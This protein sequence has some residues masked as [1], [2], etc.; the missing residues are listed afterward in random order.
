MKT[1]VVSYSYVDGM[2]FLY[3]SDGNNVMQIDA[4]KLTAKINGT[5]VEVTDGINTHIFTEEFLEEILQ[6]SQ[7][8]LINDLIG[9]RTTAYNTYVMPIYNF[10]QIGLYH[11]V[12]TNSDVIPLQNCCKLVVWNTG[13]HKATINFGQGNDISIEDHSGAITLIDSVISPNSKLLNVFNGQFIYNATGG[14]ELNI[15][16]SF[17]P[18]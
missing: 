3:N 14:A 8:W 9:F 17:I 1:D 6:E 18:I 10:N 7:Y 5:G 4:L 16:Y 2:V 11:N 12:L 13:N 15:I